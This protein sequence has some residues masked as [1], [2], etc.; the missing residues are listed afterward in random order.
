[1]SPTFYLV[2]LCFK[3]KK[4]LKI[5]QLL[6]ASG[7]SE[8]YSTCSICY[9]MWFCNYTTLLTVTNYRYKSNF[10]L[11]IVY[12]NIYMVSSFVLYFIYI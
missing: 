5:R 9:A 7:S 12:V 10:F 3:E 8:R 1:M 11:R 4:P 6:S 2:S